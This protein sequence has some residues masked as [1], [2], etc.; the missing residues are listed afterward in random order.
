M[1]VVPKTE[2]EA[3]GE[4]TTNPPFS[5]E[6]FSDEERQRV[7]RPQSLPVV[8]PISPNQASTLFVVAWIFAIAA[9]AGFILWAAVSNP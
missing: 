8:E 9:V 4:A 6:P 3:V 1:S 2:P 7:D 5:C